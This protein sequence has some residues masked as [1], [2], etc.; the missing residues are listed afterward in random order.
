MLVRA[1][2]LLK[3]ALST[4]SPNTCS[5]YDS[6]SKN[7]FPPASCLLQSNVVVRAGAQPA[8]FL[9][10]SVLPSCSFHL[11]QLSWPSCMAKPFPYLW[12]IFFFSSHYSMFIHLFMV[13]SCHIFFFFFSF[14][15]FDLWSA[16]HFSPEGCH[17][18]T[19]C[20]VL[21]SVHAWYMWIVHT[22]NCLKGRLTSAWHCRKAAG[23]S[24]LSGCY[25]SCVC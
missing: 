17:H 11:H 24:S 25:M 9:T 8:H 1:W 20:T 15:R 12:D 14:L 21:C 7:I 22:L 3:A 10:H 2:S 19:A 23:S 5:G 6:A 13:S 4:L 18:F 16:E